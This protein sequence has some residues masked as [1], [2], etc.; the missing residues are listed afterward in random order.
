MEALRLQRPLPDDVLIVVAQGKKE[1]GWKR[2]QNQNRSDRPP[3]SRAAVSV[4]DTR[5]ASRDRI[6]HQTA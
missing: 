5:E 4:P 6:L 2:S 3:D 1:D